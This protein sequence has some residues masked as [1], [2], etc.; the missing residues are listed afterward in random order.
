MLNSKQRAYLRGIANKL[1]ATFQVGKGGINDNFIIQ[2]N[3]HLTA[4][5]LVKV[6]VL[7]NSLTTS[8]ESA[9]QVSELTGADVVQVIGNKYVLYKE[10]KE[11]PKIILP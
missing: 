9:N 10:S 3:D 6:S 8:R 11:K 7:E 5:E 4:N 1:P 2:I